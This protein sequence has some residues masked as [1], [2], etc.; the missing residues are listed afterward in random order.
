MLSDHFFSS[1][2]IRYVLNGVLMVLLFLC[3]PSLSHGQNLW[4]LDACIQTAIEN[5]L[6]MKNADIGLEGSRINLKQAQAARMP[7]L[8]GSSGMFWNFGRTI[9]P[10]SNQ[11]VTETFVANNFSLNSGVILFD[12]FRITNSIKQAENDFKAG[13][14]D[15]NQAARDIALSVATSYL[16]MLLAQENLEISTTNKQVTQSQLDQLQKL[17]ESGARPKID[18]F[19]LEAQLARDDQAIIQAENNLR[20]AALQLQNA[21]QIQPSP[22]FQIMKYEGIQANLDP[23]SVDL[24]QLY[25][26][27]LTTQERVQ[28]EEL[29]LR[30]AQMGIDIAKA[31]YIPTL[32]FGA[33]LGTNYSNKGIDLAGFRPRL[34]TVR[35]LI[36]NE[37]LEVGLESQEAILRKKPY[38]D[39]IKDNLSYGFGFNLSIPIY[40]NYRNTANVQ[41]AKLAAA[42]AEINLAQQKQNLLNEVARALADAKGA[43]ASWNAATKAVKAQQAAFDA[44]KSRFDANGIS[45]FDFVN[46]KNRLDAAKNNVTLTRYEYIFRV[47]VL[48]FYLGM[49]LSLN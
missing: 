36:N 15:K 37:F 3:M 29:R 46:A 11:F 33:N 40:N 42:S 28:A 6:L 27:A 35:F 32:S 19:E 17:I 47:K 13:I 43:Q 7:S 22:D 48:E 1:S 4:T 41:R 12:G 24:D 31:A 9:D 5:S 10:T 45:S 16:S 49:P 30:S 8:N 34:D 26:K 44:V 23:Q 14:K 39:Q 25:N 20:I 38:T 21:M 2:K 18:A